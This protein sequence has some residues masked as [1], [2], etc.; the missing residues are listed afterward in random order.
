[1]LKAN[2]TPNNELL[3]R[4]VSIQFY[5]IKRLREENEQLKRQLRRYELAERQY[6]LDE[7]KRQEQDE[8]DELAY[9][10]KAQR[11]ARKLSINA[12]A[13][14][15]GTGATRIWNYEKGKGD[16]KHMHEIVERIQNLRRG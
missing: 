4:D 12:F 15:L 9:Y 8:K 10:I 7:K 13:K 11:E 1:M 2:E 14:L 6:E 16:L 3:L 5:E